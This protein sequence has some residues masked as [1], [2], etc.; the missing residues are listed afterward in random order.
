[1]QLQDLHKQ[2][3]IVAAKLEQNRK[4]QLTINHQIQNIKDCQNQL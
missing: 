1:M 2:E 3:Q 4:Q